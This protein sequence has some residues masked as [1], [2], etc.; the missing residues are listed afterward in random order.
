[1]NK[2]QIFNLFKEKPYLIGMGA[3]TVCNRYGIDLEL[4]LN[5]R[6]EWHQIE[7]V[8]SNDQYPN[9]EYSTNSVPKILI[10]DI[11][12]APLRAYVWSRWRQ[13]VYDEQMI[14]EWF[15]ICWSA[16]W[17]FEDTIYSECVTPEEIRRE[18]DSRVLGPLWN[19]LDTADIVI[20]HNGESFDIPK[21]NARF[22]VNGFNPPRPY[23]Q[24]D[25]LLVAKKQ[26]SFSSNKLDSLAKQFGLD[27]KLDTSFEL[28]SD[29]MEGKQEAL[30]YMQKYNKQDILVLENV[31]L[32]LRPFIPR[33]PNIGIYLESSSKVCSTCGSEDIEF[34]GFQYTN[35]GK[36][37]IYRCKKCGSYSRVRTNCYDKDKRKELLTSI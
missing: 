32:K 35:V 18:D 21:I 16:K 3:P 1:M 2:E 25:T 5:A 24:I 37:A 19:L 13:N 6:R 10:L 12:N 20:T 11:E 28:W 23:K 17:L 36:Y 7:D 29:C 9:N 33:H 34:C 30:D 15:I 26:F 8:Y 27:T 4:Y 31:Y 14:S 22:I